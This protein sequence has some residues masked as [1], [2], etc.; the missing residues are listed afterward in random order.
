MLKPFIRLWLWAAGWK[1]EGDP[2]PG[3]PKWVLIAYPHTSNW[4]FLL[5]LGYCRIKDIPLKWMAKDN[6][7]KGP[8]GPLF[9]AL[10]G[11][12]IDRSKAT[13]MVAKMVE[14]FNTHDRIVISVPPEGT[15]KKVE[16][17]KTGFYWLATGASVPLV[18]SYIDGPR[19]RVGLGPTIYPTGDIKADVAKIAEFYGDILGIHPEKTSPPR[20]KEEEPQVQSP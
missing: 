5:L 20:L 3:V 2:P 7:F 11:I 12:P 9:R 19:R 16:Y 4:D 1:V 13:N 18:L 17:W 6:I 8:F 10:G 14:A 15:R